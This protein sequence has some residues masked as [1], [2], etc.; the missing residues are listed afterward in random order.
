MSV[1]TTTLTYDVSLPKFLWK[2]LHRLFEQG[3]GETN[4]LIRELWNEAGFSILKRKGE[5]SAILKGVVKRPSYIPSRIFRNILECSGRIIRSQ[6]K[7]KE[8][9]EK[10]LKGVNLRKNL[11]VRNILRQ[12]ENLKKKGRKPDNYFQLSPPRQ[13]AK[14]YTLP[15]EE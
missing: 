12:I 3:K 5:A 8:I 13:S 2:H 15:N 1:N 4:K 7:R 9:F 6:I 14:I 11:L 10:L